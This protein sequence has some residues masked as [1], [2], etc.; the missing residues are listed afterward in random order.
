MGTIHF[1]AEGDIA[2]LTIDSPGKLNAFTRAM[3]AEIGRRLDE[4]AV[5][6]R[7]IGVVVTGAGD[8]CCAGQDLEES[9]QWGHDVPWVEEFE[10]FHRAF[11]R[12]MKPSVASVN[13]VAAGGGFQMALMCDSRVGCPDTRMGQPEVRTGLASVT[14]TWAMQRALGDLRA[15]EL[16]LTG[17]L[18]KSDELLQ[19]G[20]LSCVVPRDQLVDTALD[21][22]RAFAANPADSFRRTK[23]WIYESASDEL[24]R[25][26]ADAGRL[27]RMGFASGVSQAGAKKF[28]GTT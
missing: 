9:S 20:I 18:M 12:F 17:R 3:R 6:P 7:F 11:L 15:R 13:G 22:V 28:L 19:L 16:A 1:H 10:A 24:A 23:T 8:A 14:G 27:H 2:V 5:D 25:L 4:I 26:Y 21:T